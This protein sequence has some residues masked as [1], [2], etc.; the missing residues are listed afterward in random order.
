MKAIIL[1]GG[2]G[3]RLMPYTAVMPKPLM[4]IGEMP[5][6]ELLLRQLRQH[7][8]TDV[9]L[10]VNH[11]HHLIR[12]FFTDGSNLGL[13]ITYR[14]EDKP[15]GTSG[16]IAANLEQLPDHFIVTNGDLLT[17]LNFSA[18]VREHLDRGAAATIAT[19]RRTL[20]ADFGALTV[21]PDFTVSEYRE[22]PAMHFE[23]SM[24][25]Y[26]LSKK[27]VAPLIPADTFFDMPDLVRALLASSQKVVSYV[28]DC[29]WIDIG[30]PDDYARAQ[31]QFT[32][33]PDHF[34]PAA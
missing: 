30:R 5:I 3:T 23:A 11:L 20:Q 32:A 12:S 19:H 16:P 26:V 15:L 2:K 9:I 21:G 7:G 34:L 31:E 33:R 24:G 8:V 18:M 29:E 25:L 4:P 6:L 17:T 22:K 27:A 28:E 14:V 10:A 13:N 1:A